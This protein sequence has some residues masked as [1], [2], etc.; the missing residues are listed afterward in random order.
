[1]SEKKDYYK[2]LGVPKDASVDQIT[3]AYRTLA[4]RYHPDRNRSLDAEAMM[5]EINEA[6]DTLSDKQKRQSYRRNPKD[7]SVSD[8]EFLLKNFLRMDDDGLAAKL[9]GK[10]NSDIRKRR[11]IWG[12]I[13][14]RFM[15]RASDESRVQRIVFELKKGQRLLCE[16]KVSGGNGDVQFNVFH[17][18]ARLHSYTPNNLE[19]IRHSK[20]VGYVIDKSGDYCFY[21]SNNFSWVTSKSVEFAY[22]LEN[23]KMVTLVFSL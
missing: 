16:I 14:P 12:L 1:M 2:V 20:A 15:E 19:V 18:E 22:Q 5:K 3:V 8:E 17:Y 13:R 7:W 4:L 10:S 6:Y 21:F 11:A 23:K 9:K